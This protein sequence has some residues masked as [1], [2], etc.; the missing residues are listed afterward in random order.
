MTTIIKIERARF[1]I[2]KTENNGKS[3]YIYTKN[4]KLFKKQDNLRHFFIHKK[5]YTERHAIS[6]IIFGIGIYIYIY[7]SG[8]FALHDVFI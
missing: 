6:H 7:K 4:Q 5:P 2:Y 8:N 3:L 1:Y